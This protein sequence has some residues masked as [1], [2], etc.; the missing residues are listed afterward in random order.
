MSKRQRK[1]ACPHCGRGLSGSLLCA[2]CG[3]ELQHRDGVLSPTPQPEQGLEENEQ[4]LYQAISGNLEE[5]RRLLEVPQSTIEKWFDSRQGFW[6]SILRDKSMGTVLDLSP[7]AHDRILSLLAD[8][9]YIAGNSFTQLKRLVAHTG[10]QESDRPTAI[11]LDDTDPP[12]KKGT[13]DT[14]VVDR[15]DRPVTLEEAVSYMEEDGTLI[16]QLEATAELARSAVGSSKSN[17]HLSGGIWD[18]ALPFARQSFPVTRRALKNHFD[19]VIPFVHVWKTFFRLDQSTDALRCLRDMGETVPYHRV[20][21]AATRL[22]IGPLVFPRFVFVCSNDEDLPS[23]FGTEL[24]LSGN[25][26]AVSVD[27]PSCQEV[28]KKVPLGGG[29]Q[30][31][32]VREQRVTRLVREQVE[33]ISEIPLA[34]TTN[35]RLGQVLTEPLAVGG[36]LSKS[37]ARSKYKQA[38][39]LGWNWLTRFQRNTENVSAVRSVEEVRTDLSVPSLELSPPNAQETAVTLGPVH[40]DYQPK[41][42]LIDDGTVSRVIDWEYADLNAPQ[43]VDAA[44]YVLKSAYE[45]CDSLDSAIGQVLSESNAFGRFVRSRIEQYCKD[46]P[47]SLS[48]FYR[49]LAY[50]YVR[51]LKIHEQDGS[52]SFFSDM[53]YMVNVVENIWEATSDVQGKTNQV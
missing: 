41:N 32:N 28:I 31:Y 2:S 29:H 53:Y 42:I 4:L 34:E 49:Y 21:E 50:P 5:Y 37:F 6:A 38:F 40:G 52:P 47:L 17:N 18:L 12:V 13:F 10:Q 33:N 22:G 30:K 43:V 3:Y 16:L 35:T 19:E 1:L 45:V 15:T 23:S 8:E 20:L 14:V 26:R 9:L 46:R 36:P 25:N 44:Q 7:G 24:L 39:D 11:Y 51:F 48:G 27:L